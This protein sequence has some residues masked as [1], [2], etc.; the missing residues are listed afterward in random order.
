MNHALPDSLVRYEHDLEEAVR[1]DLAGSAV[2]RRRRRAGI[3]ILLAAGA[4]AAVVLGALSLL[5]RGAPSTAQPAAAA[6]I[7]QAT[8]ALTQARGTILQI[9]FTG[10]QDNG[11]GTTVTWSQESFTEQGPP[12]DSRLIN[13]RLSGT[14]SGVEQSTVSGVPQIYDPTR[15]TIYVG[16]APTGTRSTPNVRHYRFSRGPTPGSVRVRVPVAFVLVGRHGHPRAVHTISRTVIVTVAQA[17]ALRKGTDTIAWKYHASGER[18]SNPR[19]VRAPRDTSANDAS[20]LDPFSATFRGQILAVL[21]SG[22]ARVAGH[23]AV[24]GRD[25]IKIESA[26]GHTTYYVAPDSYQP[27]ELTT[28]GTTGGSVL[29]FDTYQEL[30]LSAN[31]KLLSLTAQHPGAMIDRNAADYGAAEARLFPHG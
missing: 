6:I 29:R 27:V 13:V 30:P 26:R 18:V 9:K 25:T 11:D 20:N 7:R 8:A 12:Y 24:D 15:N 17:D 28:R 3:R 21:R 23:A 19:V 31:T 4:T 10:T 16:R 14:P 5:V 1:R 22:G 2:R